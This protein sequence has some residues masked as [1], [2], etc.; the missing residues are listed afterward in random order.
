[1]NAGHSVQIMTA[2]L[3]LASAACSGEDGAISADPEPR[4]AV[5]TAA[6]V[7]L[8]TLDEE[9]ADRYRKARKAQR[10]ALEKTRGVVQ[11][12]ETASI[13]ELEDAMG[14]LNAGLLRGKV[15]LTRL[16]NEKL[17]GK[18]KLI[19]EL[20]ELNI[21]IEAAFNSLLA[22]HPDPSVDMLDMEGR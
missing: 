19:A 14:V 22:Y 7:V 1:M 20:R 12:A 2:L 4:G 18:K 15:E 8:D 11:E 6:A 3:L 5:A 21:E 17:R 10:E 16:R 9:D 13:D